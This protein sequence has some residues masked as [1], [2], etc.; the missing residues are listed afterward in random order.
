MSEKLCPETSPWGWK[1]LIITC[2]LSFLFMVIFYLAMNNEP[3]YMPMN[4]KKAAAQSEMSESSMTT[5]TMHAEHEH[6]H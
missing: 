2:I 4:Q 1:A 6:H 3:D 5:E